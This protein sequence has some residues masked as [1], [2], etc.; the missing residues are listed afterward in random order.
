M[1]FVRNLPE[2]RVEILVAG[3]LRNVEQ[4]T[5]WVKVGPSEARVKE[6]EVFEVTSN[7]PTEPFYIR[8]DG[9]QP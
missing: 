9:G 2:S 6:V 8:R 4:L 7:L 1:G 5:D 3:P